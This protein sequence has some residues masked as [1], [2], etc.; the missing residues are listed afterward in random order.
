MR[1]HTDSP[2]GIDTIA[3]DQLADLRYENQR[4]WLALKDARFQLH[5]AKR[6]NGLIGANRDWL[7]RVLTDMRCERD[8]LV[9]E[10][11]SLRRTVASFRRKGTDD[12]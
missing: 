10:V 1:N 9:A 7:A 11:T 6:S 5:E 12:D 4:L 8:R 2:D 3:E